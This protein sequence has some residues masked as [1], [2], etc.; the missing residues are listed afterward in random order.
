MTADSLTPEDAERLRAAV[1]AISQ[2]YRS[3]GN[4]AFGS[5]SAVPVLARFLLAYHDREAEQ[6][7]ALDRHSGDPI[8]AAVAA[9]WGERCEGYPEPGCPICDA[10]A[11]VD[12]HDAFRRTPAAGADGEG[13]TAPRPPRSGGTPEAA[14]RLRLDAATAIATWDGRDVPRLTPSEWA[15]LSRLAA[16]PGWIVTRAHMLDALGDMGE[17]QDRSMDHHISHLRRKLRTVGCD[18]IGTRYGMGYVWEEGR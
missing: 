2:K 6:R 10:W 16:R 15:V 5:T 12:R 11:A 1:N 9:I 8:R 18:A 17:R 13:M 4:P 14:G 3:T 7:A